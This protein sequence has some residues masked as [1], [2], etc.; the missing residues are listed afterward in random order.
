MRHTQH[1]GVMTRCSLARGNSLE[2]L[3][4]HVQGGVVSETY[5][6]MTNEIAVSLLALRRSRNAMRLGIEPG[7]LE[8][9]AS[10]I[11]AF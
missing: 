11:R 1:K 5:G 7:L 6:K 10:Q 2:G 3:C 8:P 9:R 4:A